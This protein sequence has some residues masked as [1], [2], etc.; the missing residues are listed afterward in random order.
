MHSERNPRRVNVERGIYFRKTAGGR[1][2]EIGYQGSD[3]R[4]RWQVV[5]GGLKQAR[6]LRGEI[7]SKLARGE[8][9]SPS[10]QAFAEVA[11]AWLGTKTRLAPRTRQRYEEILRVH[12]LPPFA[13]RRISDICEDDVVRLI[14]EAQAAGSSAGT[15]RKA[16]V[17]LSGVLNHAVRRGMI[18]ANPVK[19]LQRGERPMVERREMRILD[20]DGI[21]RLLAA[22][23]D[24]YWS[25]LA[26]AL[27]T[28]LRLGELLGLTWADVDLAVGHLKVRK[29]LDRGG[30]RVRPKTERAIREVELMPALARNT[31]DAQGTTFRTRPRTG[32]RLRLL[33]GDRNAAPLSK[34]RPSGT[35]RRGR[36]NRSRQRAT[37]SL[38]RSA[39]HVREPADR[40]GSRRRL[41]LTAT[42]ARVDERHA[43]RLRPPVRPGVAR[44]PCASG[45]GR[46]VW[47][48]FGKQREEPAG[49]RR[50]A[51]RLNRHPFK[52]K[53]ANGNLREP[54]RPL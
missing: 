7:I 34:R 1:R 18:S 2:Y 38:S 22:A 50:C 20:S 6:A 16:L 25:L 45:A 42:R 36:A 12:L 29:Q 14:A 26:T 19:R 33:H 4:W 40:R 37:P 13:A 43:R 17:V 54:P 41:R 51:G 48:A 8:R 15:A 39:T 52:E 46:L 9:V 31:P 44:P 10:R 30:A 27:F 47:K 28:G 21:G 23:D 53:R 32:Q 49:Q 3:G 5:E 35:R 11:D 24:R